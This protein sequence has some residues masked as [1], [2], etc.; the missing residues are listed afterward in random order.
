LGYIGAEK[1]LEIIMAQPKKSF[2]TLAEDLKKIRKRPLTQAEID[3]ANRVFGGKNISTQELI[4]RMKATR[5]RP[6]KPTLIEKFNKIVELDEK[7]ER[8][9][10]QKK[11]GKNRPSTGGKVNRVYSEKKISPRESHERMKAMR[12]RPHKPELAEKF[13]KII[14]LDEKHERKQ[15]QKNPGEK[16]K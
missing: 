12:K 2:V 13:N 4:E 6:H 14:E 3:K 5:K 1:R 7:H 9:Q 8:E 10:Q 15:R 11:P 16:I